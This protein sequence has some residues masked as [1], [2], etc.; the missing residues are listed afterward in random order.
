MVSCIDEDEGP[1]EVGMGDGEPA[2]N[3]LPNASSVCIISVVVTATP[4]ADNDDDTDDND[5]ARVEVSGGRVTADVDDEPVTNMEDEDKLGLGFDGANNDDDTDVDVVD[6]KE[7]VEDSLEGEI[8]G[9]AWSS[10]PK[11][12]FRESCSCC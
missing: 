6:D 3:M 9:D 5:V 4:T 7:E 2:I 10:V 1:D 11:T 12:R 8:S